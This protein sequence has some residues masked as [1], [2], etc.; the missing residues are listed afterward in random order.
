MLTAAQRHDLIIGTL[1]ALG[2]AVICFALNGSALLGNWRWDDPS[3]LYH[4]HTYSFIQDWTEPQV[5]RE[6]IRANLTPWLIFSYEID[7]I[8]FGLQPAMFYLHQLLSLTIA[9]FV[10]YLLLKLWISPVFAAIGALLFVA[11]APVAVIAQQ[12]MTRH[13]ADGM[14]FCLLAL[15]CYVQFLR[16]N[17]VIFVLAATALYALAVSS[18]EIYVPLVVLLPFIPE[19]GWRERITAAL[20]IAVVAALYIPWRY[21]MLGNLADGY[22]QSSVFLSPDFVPVVLG[23]FARMPVLMFGSLW[24]LF[25][26]IYI[27]LVISYAWVRRSWLPLSLLILLLVL[28][29]LVAVVRYPGITS[30]DRYLYLFWAAISFSVAY[31]SYYLYMELPERLATAKTAV[32]AFVIPLLL[33]TTL[34]ETLE[35]RQGVLV[36]AR[37]YDAQSQFMWNNSGELAFEPTESVKTSYWYV[38]YMQQFKAG[39]L[40]GSSIPVSV[41]DDY[42][43]TDDIQ[44]LLRYD[45]ECDCMADISDTLEARRSNIRAN[46]RESA[47]LNVEFE[48][49][50]GNFVWQFG[51]Y[52]DGAYRIVSNVLGVADVP[53]AGELGATLQAGAKIMVR[54]TSPEGW[55]TYSENLPVVHDGPRVTWQR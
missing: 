8:L 39:L 7:L 47:P 6:Y 12:L 28:A 51:P 3:I 27:G 9:A 48:Y 38:Y 19:S 14:V 52:T 53:P 22:T 20:P 24:P 36:T 26:V 50:S 43:L 17:R 5:W 34:A 32:M 29:P 49:S 2:L 21:Y 30:P 10:L 4:L 40:P 45:H 55:V 11:G 25:V 18:K 23:S 44:R 41:V 46:L 54:Y 13:Y 33:L 31:Y 1:V 16:N 15:W 35:V 42:F 37:E